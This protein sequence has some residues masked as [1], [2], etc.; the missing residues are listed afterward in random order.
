MEETKESLMQVA[1]VELMWKK[2]KKLI[3]KVKES[4]EAVEVFRTVWHHD[5]N[6][7]ERC[8]ALFMNRVN[9]VIAVS[10]ISAGGVSGTVID[11]KILFAQALK[12]LAS[13]I[14]LAHNHPSGNL[15]PSGHDKDI[16]TKVKKGCE[17]FDMVLVDHVILTEDDH[18]SFANEGSL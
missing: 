12:L 4:K 17:V 2:K 5:I 6:I 3:T 13:G 9:N 1:E 10:E 11:T 8:Y 7:R 14:I 15:N 16:T 18:Y